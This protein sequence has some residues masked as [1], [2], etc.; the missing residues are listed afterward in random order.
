MKFFLVVSFLMSNMNSIDRPLFVFKSPSF[1]SMVACQKYVDENY[2]NIYQV[3][4]ASYNYKHSPEAIYCLTTDA[5]K[6]LFEYNY[7]KEENKTG[8]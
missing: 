5:M 3:A 8:V 1:E 2:M 6:D 7:G 4:S